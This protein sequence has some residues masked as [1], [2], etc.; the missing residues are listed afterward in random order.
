MCFTFLTERRK[1]MK[2][3][4]DIDSKNPHIGSQDSTELLVLF[5]WMATPDSQRVVI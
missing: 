1:G 5:T 2:K 4:K 3:K